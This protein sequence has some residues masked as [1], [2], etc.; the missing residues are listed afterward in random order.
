M[1]KMMRESFR[2]LKWIL[3]GLVIIFV[4]WGIYWGSSG[5]RQ[6]SSDMA[7]VAAKVGGVIIP[8]QEFFREMRATEDRFRQMYG[9]QY[10]ALKGSLD[11]AGMTLQNMVDRQLMLVEAHRMGIEVTDKELLDKILTF[12]AFRRQDGSFVGE[13]LY[14]QI[15]RANQTTPEAFENS[16]RQELTLEKLQQ[17]I[18]AGIVIPDSDLEREYRRRNES[19]SFDVLFVPIQRALPSVKVSDAEARAYYDAHQDQF[20]HPEQ[21]QLRYLLVDDAALRRSVSVPEAQIAEYYKSHQSEFTSGEEVHARH[22][23]IRPK[24]QDDAGWQAALAKA[25]EVYQKATA[26]GADFAALAKQYSDD[27]GSKD[28]GGDLG[29]FSRGKM[30]KEFEDA[31]FALKP[32]QVSAPV[33]SQFGYHVIK[34]EGRRPGG[35]RALDEVREQIRV[36]LAEGLA[37]SEGSRRATALR[38]KIDAAK[39]TTEEQWHALTD[40]VVSSNVTPFFGGSDSIPGLGSDPELLAEVTAAKEGFIGGPRRTSRGWIVYRVIKVRKAGVTPFDEAKNEAREGALRAKAIDAL[41]AE[42]NS[43]RASLAAGPLAAQ[44]AA[45]GGK[46]S[47]VKEYKR[48][49]AIPG[50]GS[51]AAL[52]DAVFATAV[53]ELTP[54][55]TVGQRGVA[56]ARITAKKTI[57]PAAFAKEKAQLRSSMVQEEEQRILSAMLSEAKREHPVTVNSELLERFKPSRG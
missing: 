14:A 28:S 24:T 38:E 18:S 54:V 15:L 16:L 48:G 11:L 49:A 53:G 55:V 3:W 27:P 36:K 2:S 20:S 23:L 30:V 52:E 13:N 44:E 12:P 51:S 45:L 1:L 21:R 41:T 26:A 56:I 31:V 6:K 25:K 39:L 7:G 32:G 46:V 22:I 47:P 34:L 37:D 29:W 57:D 35:V 42:I 19:V 8:E 5:L 43:K 9:K 33:K 4:F 10:D 40:D 50:V 17:A